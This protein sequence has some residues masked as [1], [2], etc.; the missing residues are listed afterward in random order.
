[1][2]FGK[3]SIDVASYQS[4]GA[5]AH[6]TAAVVPQLYCDSENAALKTEYTYIVILLCEVA[7]SA[8][9]SKCLKII[10]RCP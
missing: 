9:V 8:V 10:Y 1:M 2:S 5:T 7:K 3:W 4:R 6:F